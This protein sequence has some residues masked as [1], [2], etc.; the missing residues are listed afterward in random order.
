MAAPLGELISGRNADGVVFVR[1]NLQ[2]VS[3]HTGI[4]RCEE[5]LG[6][7]RP[8]ETLRLGPSRRG[9]AA[10]QPYARVATPAGGSVQE[11]CCPV[12]EALA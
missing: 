10:A 1:S 4:D 9:A 6:V 11:M 12:D 7:P 3:R 8:D 2:L 5:C